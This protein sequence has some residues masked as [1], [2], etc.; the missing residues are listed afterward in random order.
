MDAMRGFAVLLDLMLW[1]IYGIGQEYSVRAIDVDTRKTLANI[2][3]PCATTAH[4][5]ALA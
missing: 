1:P 3:I 2:P 4:I 5:L